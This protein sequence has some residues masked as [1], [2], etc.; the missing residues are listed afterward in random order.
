MLFY[1]C[2][3]SPLFNEYRSQSHAQHSRVLKNGSL[4]SRSESLF[5]HFWKDEGGSIA[6]THAWTLIPKQQMRNGEEAG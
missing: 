6:H 4:N 5:L 1:C 2:F 3:F